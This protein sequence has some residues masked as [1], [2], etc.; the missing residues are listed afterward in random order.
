ME[1]FCKLVCGAA[2][3]LFGVIVVADLMKNKNEEEFEM[4]PYHNKIKQRMSEMNTIAIT[5]NIIG[6][7]AAALAGNTHMLLA[8]GFLMA[9]IALVAT[10]G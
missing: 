3:A 4:Y 2:V 1:N 6:M 10:K 7:F 5:A 9:T 8:N